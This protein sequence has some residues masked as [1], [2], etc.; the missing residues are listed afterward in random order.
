[1]KKGLLKFPPDT[2]SGF[3][4]TIDQAPGA[5][6][7]ERP[8]I[9]LSPVKRIR[10]KDGR[11]Y[12]LAFKMVMANPDWK[13]VF[14]L[15]DIPQ[16]PYGHG[17]IEKDGIIYDPVLDVFFNKDILYDFVK[18]VALVLTCKEACKIISR[19]KKY[20][21]GFP[22]YQELLAKYCEMKNNFHS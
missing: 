5:L 6:I 9:D 3:I 10:Q 19:D 1:M 16:G 13:L 4:W 12:E 14:A 2:S 8:L 20:G 11:C 7:K 17:Y 18:P 22:E 15:W 21:P